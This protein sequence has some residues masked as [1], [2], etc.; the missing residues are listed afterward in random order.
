M[1]VL[2]LTAPAGAVTPHPP[3]E[4]REPISV[5]G[6]FSSSD[7]HPHTPLV[8]DDS[9]AIAGTLGVS[10]RA[11]ETARGML[12][13]HLAPAGEGQAGPL[14]AT[15]NGA[16]RAVISAMGLMA[17]DPTK[18]AS[19]GVALLADPL[20]VLV[21]GG[22]ERLLHWSLLPSGPSV[23]SRADALR[24]L[25]ALASGGHLTFQMGSNEPLPPLYV[26]GA[27][28]ADEHEWRLFEDLA[29]LEE[30]SGA[31]I[32]MPEAVSADEATIAAQAAGWARTQQIGAQITGPIEFALRRQEGLS[33][34]PDEI[35]LHQD[36][37]VRL[38]DI[39]IPLGVATAQIKATRVEK[40]ES[41]GP[42]PRYRVTPATKD[43]TLWL[44]P[45][46]GRHLPPQRTQAESISAPH[47]DAL[48]AAREHP[49]Y[50]RPA[51]R[52]LREVLATRGRRP[53]ARH[54]A[55]TAGLLDDLRGE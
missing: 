32:P 17:R 19:V 1:A 39:D 22:A 43:L 47:P 13:R 24:F 50:C 15:F 33:E 55:G 4:I 52:S 7:P 3:A 38:L 53:S 44:T 18:P 31:R 46:V 30:W 40:I 9:E 23:T 12:E 49:G 5:T 27:D 45:P 26:E 54:V 36:Y 2:D 16:H 37:G 28:W 25:R 6:R 14:T 10:V 21:V 35:R 11:V 48:H 41:T 8:R 20:I 29:V 51:R 42:E 34:A